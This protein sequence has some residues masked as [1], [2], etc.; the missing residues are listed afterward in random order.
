MV[1]EAQQVAVGGIGVDPDQYRLAALEYLVMRANADAQE[2][3]SLVAG[4]GLLDRRLN[5]V[6]NRARRDI[7]VEHAGQQF[8]HA[9]QR[10]VTDQRQRQYQLP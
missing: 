5:H 3:L 10:T 8:H 9:A 6:V 4:S 2:V 7:I 1:F